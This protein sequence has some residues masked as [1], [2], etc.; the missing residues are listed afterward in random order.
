MILSEL[1]CIRFSLLRS[2][3]FYSAARWACVCS[4]MTVCANNRLM[5]SEHNTIAR[6]HIVISTSMKLVCLFVCLF[7]YLFIIFQKE[8]CVEYMTNSEKIIKSE[9]HFTS[10]L[11]RTL[12][13]E[14]CRLKMNYS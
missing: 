13:K 11:S 4:K 14:N 5:Q 3:S 7:I 1:C 9:A 8:G 2:I 6:Q 10:D 12:L